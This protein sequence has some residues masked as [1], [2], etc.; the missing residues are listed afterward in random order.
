MSLIEK[1]KLIQRTVGAKADGIYGNET[2]DKMLSRLGALLTPSTVPGAVAMVKGTARN[3]S[4]IFLHCTATREGQDIDAAT[5]KRWHVTPV[6]QGGRGWADIGYHFVIRLDGTVEAGRDETIPGAHVAGFNAGSIGVVYVGGLD[7]QGKSKDTRTGAQKAAMARLCKELV[8]AYPGARVLGHRD[9][10]PD[11]NG[12]GKVT[13][14][15]WLKDCPCF[16]VASW[17]ESVK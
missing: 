10:S 8:S 11:R 14:N 3:I 6:A 16:D 1:T 9:A 4:R 17:W 2:A 15:E 13:A 5:I 7:A 12:D